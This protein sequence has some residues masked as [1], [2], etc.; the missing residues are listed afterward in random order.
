MIHIGAKF[1]PFSR[2]I[3]ARCL[4]PGTDLVVETLRRKLLI[5]PFEIPLR[6]D[7]LE[8]SFTLQQDLEKGRVKILGV[9][10]KASPQGILVREGSAKEF[11]L[12][13]DV[14]F[15]ERTSPLET[16]FLG[17]HKAQDIDLVLRRFDL[18]ELLPL[19]YRFSQVQCAP[20]QKQ[21][22]V[23]TEK[24]LRDWIYEAFSDSFIAKA[25]IWEEAHPIIR[26]QFIQEEGGKV[27]LLPNRLFAQG[28]FLSGQTSFGSIDFEWA[29][30]T[31]RRVVLRVTVP[32][33]FQL[34]GIGSCRIRSAMHEKGKRHELLTPFVLQRG[35]FFLDRF[36]V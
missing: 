17:S 13:S 12:V 9:E 23:W 3:G 22:A 16:L 20:V 21:T 31:L 18:E 33:S 26:S 11:Q 32:T 28:R 15:F 7:L 29:K 36:F 19:V 27:T 8:D 4:L 24:Q 5:G 2:R 30:Y 34:Q 10:V 35:M 14:P 25:P 6:Q 1:R